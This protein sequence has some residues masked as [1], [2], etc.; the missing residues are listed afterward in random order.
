MI[1]IC[2]FCTACSHYDT[3][4]AN[5]GLMQDEMDLN[6]VLPVMEKEHLLSHNDKDAINRETTN[7]DRVKALVDVMKWTSQRNY[8]A[9]LKV[10][11]KARQEKIVTALGELK[12][13][14]CV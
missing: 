6:Q 7:R 5:L 4:E 3:L 9:F 2:L 10:L 11:K 12:Y 1:S 13:F 14:K 8:K